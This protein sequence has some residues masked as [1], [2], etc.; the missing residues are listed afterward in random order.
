MT[1][2]SAS[3]SIDKSW[4]HSQSLGYDV[5]V[6]AQ[7]GLPLPVARALETLELSRFCGVGETA[8]YAMHN[9]LLRA[10]GIGNMH[11][12]RSAI[13]DHLGISKQAYSAMLLAESVGRV[14]TRAQKE[15][16]GV[17]MLPNGHWLLWH[18]QAV[19]LANIYFHHQLVPDKPES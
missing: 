9:A 19:G 5:A 7:T 6:D 12:V 13:A 2:M 10:A 16:W 4:E 17:A 14:L 1:I 11:G 8:G 15:G 18:P 3:R